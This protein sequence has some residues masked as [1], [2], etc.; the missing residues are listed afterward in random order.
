MNEIKEI[1]VDNYRGFDDTL[2]PLKEVNFFVGENS[3]GKTSI[4]KLLDLLASSEFWFN[5]NFRNENVDF[6][7][8]GEL[9]ENLH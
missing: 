9:A 3:T 5:G 8:Y 4:L 1:Y 6:S 7:Y 2:I